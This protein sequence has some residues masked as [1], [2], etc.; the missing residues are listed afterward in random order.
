MHEIKINNIQ[1]TYL[2]Y[3]PYGCGI[4]CFYY[5]MWFHYNQLQYG[6]YMYVVKNPGTHFF[7]T[8]HRFNKNNCQM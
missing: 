2:L 7:Y 6:Q 1:M 4:I 5:N 3:H 8:K